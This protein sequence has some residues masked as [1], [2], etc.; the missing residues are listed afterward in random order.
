[1]TRN[2]LRVAI[3][4]DTHAPATN[5]VVRSIEASRAA[6]R[7]RGVDVRLLAPGPRGAAERGVKTFPSVET[8]L[9]P[10]LRLSLL[11]VLPR[12]LRDADV[13]HVHT[14]GPL[15]VAAVLAARRARVPVVYTYHTRFDDVVRKLGLGERTERALVGA[16]RRVHRAIIHR[17]SALVAPTAAMAD[18]LERAYGFPCDVIPTGVDLATFR[19]M[20]RSSSQRPTFLSLGRLAPEK[21]VDAVLRAFAHVLQREPDARLVIGGSGPDAASLRSLARGLGIAHA[22]EWLGF[23]PEPDL[24]RVYASADVFVSASRFETQGLTV[25]EAMASGTPAA[26]AD[27]PVFAPLARAGAA[28]LFRPDE[29]RQG[30]EAMLRAYRQRASLG[31]EGLKLARACSTSATGR[32]LTSLYARLAADAPKL[33][34]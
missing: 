11:P 15:G 14:P 30:A 18:E 4:T 13:V 17:L 28:T 10:D 16:D 34:A 27:C 20:A 29:P 9:Y 33:K 8:S 21:S 26:L 19:P 2:D 7:E 5:G 1:M 12:H 23:V 3:V 31:A 22:V 32:A 6:L 24:P 25:L